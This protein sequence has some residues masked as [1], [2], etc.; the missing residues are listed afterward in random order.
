MFSPVSLCLHVAGWWKNYWTDVAQLCS[1]YVCRFCS[2]EQWCKMISFWWEKIK[3]AEKA[4]QVFCHISDSR[5]QENVWLGSNCSKR[6]SLSSEEIHTKRPCSISPNSIWPKIRIF[7][8]CRW[9][10]FREKGIYAKET[11]QQTTIWMHDLKE[12]IN[13]TIFK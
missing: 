6:Y 10:K 4:K 8:C 3:M 9:C 13:T 11:S 12:H 2:L 1:G 7:C 5:W